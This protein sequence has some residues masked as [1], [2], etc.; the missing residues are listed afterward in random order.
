MTAIVKEVNIA[1]PISEVWAALTD[2]PTIS[3]WMGDNSAR[4]DLEVG[5]AYA[6]FDGETTGRLVRIEAP[7]RLDYTWRQS[8]WQPGWED[9][10]VSWELNP[11][12]KHT[13]LKLTHS[14]FPNVEER[15]GHDEGWD[16]YWLEPMVDYLE[17]QA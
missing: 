17:R 2:A 4:V 15:D 14:N 1:A 7:H 16:L 13:R 11:E 10:L 5:G 9:S 6:L 8:T 3:A 12:G